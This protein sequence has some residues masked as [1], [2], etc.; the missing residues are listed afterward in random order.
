MHILLPHAQIDLD[1]R[2]LC[3]NDET[4]PLTKTEVKLLTYM[5]EH[6]DRVIAREELL[7]EVWGYHRAI[8]T[9]AVANA[10]ARLRPK[11]ELDARDPIHLI[12][13]HG[14][15]Y[16][17]QG[18]QRKAA[19]ELKPPD[20]PQMLGAPVPDP[21]GLGQLLGREAECEWLLQH[22]ADDA[23]SIVLL[24]GPGGIGKSHLVATVT[25]SL[26]ANHP[27]IWCDLNGVFRAGVLVRRL[28]QRLDVL[29]KAGASP[30]AHLEQIGRAL[31]SRGP[32]V[33]V[34]DGL[35]QLGPQAVGPLVSWQGLAPEVHWWCTSRVALEIE[36]A[37]EWPLACLE[38]DAGVSLFRRSAAQRGGVLRTEDTPTIAEIVRKLDGLPL[39]IELAASWG[40]ML[41]PKQ[42]LA[43][44][45]ERFALLRSRDAEMEPHQRTLLQ[46]LDDSFSQLDAA[47]Q[48]VL[49]GCAVFRGGFEIEAAEDVLDLDSSPGSVGVLE[50]LETL[51]RHSLLT[52]HAAAETTEIRY[53]L[54]HSVWEY[55]QARLDETGHAQRFHAQHAS[56]YLARC[57]SL[58]AAMGTGPE[59]AELQR[60]S[61][62]L[63]AIVEHFATR[64][65]DIATRAALLVWYLRH[66]MGHPIDQDEILGMV[67]DVVDPALRCRG[68]SFRGRSHQALGDRDVSAVDLDK[69][70]ALAEALNDPGIRGLVAL[71]RC[72]CMIQRRDLDNALLLG[73]EAREWFTTAGDRRGRFMAMERIARVLQ[74]KGQYEAATDLYRA[75]LRGF[76]RV[77]P[78][79]ALAM[80]HSNL[81]TLLRAQRRFDEAAEIFEIAIRICAEIGDRGSELFIQVNLANIWLHQG[82]YE[83]AIAIYPKNI[84][85]SRQR[86]MFREAALASVNY[87]MAWILSGDLAQAKAKLV[88]SREWAE[89]LDRRDVLAY[90]WGLLGYVA[91]RQG[92]WSTAQGCYEDSIRL[93]QSLRMDGQAAGFGVF[94]AI[95][96]ASRGAA[97]LAAEALAEAKRQL[98][99]SPSP[100]DE[101]LL[102][103]GAEALRR[104]AGGTKVEPTAQENL[105][106]VDVTN[107]FGK[108][109]HV[110]LSQ[111]ENRE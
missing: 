57:A 16:R 54:S 73:E 81:A 19:D 41:T 51:R 72:R 53:S 52:C 89:S 4:R 77:G 67:D 99:D 105:P 74:L 63:L 55:A 103:I 18:W 100:D 106:P 48:R 104:G 86:G 79:R 17:F 96:H 2:L 39:A 95:F 76:A 80:A 98:G 10:M 50:H 32:I 101:A 36:G 90:A 44:L 60:E 5:V 12:T 84:Q 21:R 6:P 64:D 38:E 1:K 102:A 111:P 30:S 7:E 28:A 88:Q 61:E 3:H 45:R 66:S 109:A 23:G 35:E 25:D 92:R 91:H 40:G 58:E 47:Q 29:L 31:S 34:L 87:G 110:L 93:C 70:Q 22:V 24:V 13:V 8:E 65:P 68:L 75:A 42:I 27:V 20:R 46:T 97:G 62:N 69:A 33:V 94:L 83:E 78:M 85:V 26:D 82:H 107:I 43:R 9:R 49:T 15:G 37:Q 56:H 14:V 71:S 108:L 59:L 11:I